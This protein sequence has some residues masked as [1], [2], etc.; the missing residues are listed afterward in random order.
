MA[1]GDFNDRVPWNFVD[2]LLRQTYTFILP[3]ACSTLVMFDIEEGMA[4]Y[5]G[6]AYAQLEHI[7]LAPV[8][9]CYCAE[10]VANA[11]SL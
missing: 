10:S 11:L 7:V 3:G 1:L 9:K 5:T 4:I 8:L 6:S 2:D